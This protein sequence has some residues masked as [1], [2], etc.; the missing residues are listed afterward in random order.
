MI[1][2]LL[3]HGWPGSVREFYEIIPKITTPGAIAKDVVF[4]VV[5]PCLPGYGWSQGSSKTGFGIA[6][7][8]I[9]LHNLMQRLGYKEYFIQGG[10]WGSALGSSI[11]T[12][13]PQHVLGYH[14]NM[15]F[16]NTPLAHI[17]MGIASLY[18]SAFVEEKHQHF[19]FPRSNKFLYL[20][21]ESGYMHLQ[22]TKPDTIGK[23]LH[24]NKIT[25][26]AVKKYYLFVVGIVLSSN[27]IGL[28]A[29]ILEK[30]STWTNVD[31]RKLIDG[32]WDNYSAEYKDAIL[33]NIMIY[34]LTNSI[35]TSMRLYSEA[36]TLKQMALELDRVPTNVPFACA[37]FKHDLDQAMDWQLAE[38]YRNIV[39]TTYHD[40]GGHFAA[41]E[42]ADLLF[43]DFVEFVR[44][45]RK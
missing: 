6:E 24:S 25:G 9:V 38:K 7:M 21:E 19:F 41:M 31:F 2:L 34:H 5:V 43:S 22:A 28:A 15:C 36:F 18:P 29:Y 23:H 44:K 39:Q 17:K 13:F 30:F 4:E 14:T 45:V 8:S 12:I 27:P 26:K 42:Q 3:L 10:D 16:A 35:T 32:G 20:M 37:R 33:D 1:P 11:A 40:V